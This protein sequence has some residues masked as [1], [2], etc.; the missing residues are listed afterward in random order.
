MKLTNMEVLNA[1]GALA[2]LME[3]DLPIKVSLDVAIISNLVD[4]QTKAYGQVLQ[5][6]YKKYSVKAE[7][8]ENGGVQFTC[9]IGADK[10]DDGLAINEETAK[11]RQ[12]NMEAFAEKL[13]D[14]LEANTADMNFK[15]IKLPDNIT[16]KPEIL[17]SLTEFVEI[18]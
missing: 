17:K 10:P 16:I 18:E 7:P 2:K 12:E 14:L 9:T 5:N 11:L 6:L 13:N 1:S 15:K 3:M 8:Q 4:V